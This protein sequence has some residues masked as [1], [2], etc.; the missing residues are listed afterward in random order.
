MRKMIW[1]AAAVCTLLLPAVLNAQ[2]GM[3]EPPLP[4]SVSGNLPDVS[5]L[6]GIAATGPESVASLTNPA[7][8]QP[9]ETAIMPPPPPSPALPVETQPAT[10]FVP[11][12]VP[13]AQASQNP[14]FPSGTPVPESFSQGDQIIVLT[15]EQ[16]A[17]LCRLTRD[18]AAVRRL[19]DEPRSNEALARIIDTGKSGSA[20]LGLGA[21]PVMPRFT[22][23]A[24]D[25]VIP[26][27]SG[28]SWEYKKFGAF[29]TRLDG[30]VELAAGLVRVDL[31]FK[32][33]GRSCVIVRGSM[34]RNGFL[35]GSLAVEGYDAW[36][37]P[38]KTAIQMAGLLLRD[39]G[40]PSG[41]VLAISGSDPSGASRAGHLKFPIADPVPQKVQKEKR[42]SERRARRF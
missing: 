20:L 40:M 8:F 21:F 26:S 37:R 41:G 23:R 11:P 2:T 38:W 6:P 15:P 31:A 36:G 27:R 42:R 1:R 32:A 34:K 14:A 9:P 3:Q 16:A 7:S 17:V 13:D 39:D 29:Q 24:D 28:D 4:Q 30:K 25:S 5:T 35:D 22:A 12:Q 19:A 33:R 18:I 10:G